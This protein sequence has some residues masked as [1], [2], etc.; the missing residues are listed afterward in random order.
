VTLLVISPDY[1]SHALPLISIARAW[2]ERG[3]RVVV[4][5]GAAVAPLVRAA[6]MEHV[7]LVMSRGSN[8]GVLRQGAPSGDGENLDTFFEA[9]K[10]GMLATLRYQAQK[11]A[12]DLLWRPRDVARATI[13]VIERVR[14]DQVLVDHLAIAATIGLRAMG[15][16]YG[17]V[18]LGHPTALTMG[19]E[20]YGVPV[21]WPASFAVDPTR[22]ADLRAVAS[23]VREAV[24]F[25][26]ERALRSIEPGAGPVGD[27]FAAHGDVVLFVYPDRLHDPARTRRLPEHAFLGSA[28]RREQLPADVRG[29]LDREDGRPLVVVSFGTFLSARSDVLA[30]VAGALRRLDVRVAMAT[31]A[32][33]HAH[34]GSL[35]DDWL[36]RPV[37]PQVAL[38]Q[39]ASVLVS[40]GGNNSI[41][42][43][44]SVGVPL[45]VLPFSTDQFD[46]A[47]AIEASA[48]GIA[49]D[50]NRA[51]RPLIAG[52]VA[53]MLRYPP[54]IC[55]LIGTESQADPGPEIAFRTMQRL[56]PPAQGSGAV[57]PRPSGVV[58]S[59]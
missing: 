6:G 55:R 44:L 24:T 8:P 5:S 42:E 58:R 40:H 32:S 19:D 50:P 53:G 41:T 27:V 9:T 7:E 51:S 37:I 23:G 34:L 38:L 52:S 22:M 28:G 15:V 46:G 1:A 54:D 33:Q 59:A 45:V 57:A 49:L 17:D 12:S 21:A 39:R 18:V 30:R 13:E 20:V 16:R 35:P 43:A 31:G 4:A 10:Q 3:H 56:S 25:A 11:R 26:Y 48:A 29:W 47:A 36:V 2:Q 14:P